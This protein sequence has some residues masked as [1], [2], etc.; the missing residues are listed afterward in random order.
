MNAVTTMTVAS[1]VTQASNFESQ[2]DRLTDILDQYQ[3]YNDSLSKSLFRWGASVLQIAVKHYS[4]AT[5]EMA[6][7]AS[8]RI[9]E[10]ATELL[11]NPLDG[12]SLQDPI[13][14]R[15]WTWEREVHQDCR[16]LF[17]TISPLDGEVM[18]K[19]P[20]AHFF[21]QEMI[22]WA[23]VFTPAEEAASTQ[24]SLFVE[25]SS[26]A[27]AVRRFVYQRLAKAAIVQKQQR[28]L[29][30]SME[31]ALISVDESMV[32]MRALDLSVMERAEEKAACH[33]AALDRQIGSIT[34]VHRDHLTELSGQISFMEESHRKSVAELENRIASVD[35][36]NIAVSDALRA[37][38][39]EM[40]QAH[41]SAVV[42]LDAQI[43]AANVAHQQAVSRLETQLSTT[44]AAHSTAISTIS[45][46]TH[47]HRE[48]V[49]KLEGRVVASV[50]HASQVQVSLSQAEMRN[51]QCAAEIRQLRRD[52]DYARSDI[53]RLQEELNDDDS[54][55]IM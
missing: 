13:L 40:H 47:T 17:K 24:L 53:R 1:V 49:T 31:F 46:M 44:A 27:A 4:S 30:E 15:D 7:I 41:K 11:V 51:A 43:Q 52:Y 9:H 8:E 42:A 2:I 20:A 34:Q 10:L 6:K 19:T 28:D 48:A 22:V 26:T 50:A 12:R 39:I 29:Q 3:G 45:S 37:Q 32:R 33:E 36:T 14:E 25:G 55:T 16:Q 35:Q 18:N 5:E 54:C 21:A 23:K 38:L